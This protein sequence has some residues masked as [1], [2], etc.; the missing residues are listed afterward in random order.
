[1]QALLAHLRVAA[2]DL[3]E[4]QS[5]VDRLVKLLRGMPDAEVDPAQA[6]SLLQDLG[7]ADMVSKLQ[8]LPCNSVVN[9]QQPFQGQGLPQTSSQ[10]GAVTPGRAALAPSAA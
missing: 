2:A 6:G 8:I 4:L 10:Q 3:D 9:S 1:M 7:L 5:A